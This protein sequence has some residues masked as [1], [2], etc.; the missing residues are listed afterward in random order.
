M[1]PAAPKSELRRASRDVF[2]NIARYYVDLITRPRLDTRRFYER[3]LNRYAIEENLLSPLKQGKGVI[4][5]S[6]HF[7]DAELVLQGLSHLGVRILALTEPSSRRPYR[8]WCTTCA[9]RAA[10]PTCP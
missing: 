8:A 1:G 7:G 2:R 4:L 10:T 3:R 6:A 9:P 5:V